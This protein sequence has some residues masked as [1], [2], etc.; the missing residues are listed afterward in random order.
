MSASDRT[1]LVTGG[2]SGIGENIARELAGA[3]M[4]VWVTGRTAAR[5]ERVAGEIGGQALVG[6]VANEDDVARWFETAGPIDL[7]VNNAGVSGPAG[8]FEQ[9]EPTSWWRVFEVNVRGVFLCC[10][11]AVPG[12][13]ARGAGRIVNVASGAAYLPG[14]GSPSTAYGP[15]LPRAASSYSRSVPGSFGRR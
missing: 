6:D 13:L 11:A 14:G 10:H 1:A 8:T 7:L 9:E 3:G 12:M 15:S 4:D 5:L 2:G